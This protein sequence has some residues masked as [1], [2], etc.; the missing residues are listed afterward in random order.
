MSYV[1][2]WEPP[3]GEDGRTLLLLHGTGADEHDLLPLGRALLPGAG[4]LSPRGDVDEGG[5]NRF[6]RRFAEGV[7][8]LGDVAFR[9][10]RL[11]D[12]VADCAHQ[13]AF[14]PHRVVAVGFSNGA[15]I[16]AATLFVRPHAIAEAVL[17][18]AQVTFVPDPLPDL[19]GKRVLLAS[20]RADT[21]IPTHEASELAAIL[22]QCGAEVD[23]AWA[24]SGHRL[25]EDEVD[26]ARDWLD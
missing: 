14:D 9:A 8:D 12:F 10:E 19:T 1:H 25:T 7:F 17:F 21:L 16:A 5:S 23:H 24:D 13:Y 6:F 4:I 26:L 18:R 2:V 15:N 20:G 22:R 11:G 3:T